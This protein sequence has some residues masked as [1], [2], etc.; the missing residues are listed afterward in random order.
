MSDSLSTGHIL[1]RMYDALLAAYGPQG[2]WPGD[3]PTEIVIGAILTQNTNWK[4]VEKAIARMKEAGLLDWAALREVPIDRLAECIRPAGYFRIKA[5]RLK[6]FVAWL[7]NRHAGTLE[8]LA[9]LSTQPLRKGLL[10]VSG[11]GRETADA[12]LLYALSRPT[13]VVD[14]YTVRV[15][16]RHNLLAKSADYEALK[17]YF[18]N[19][20]PED[21]TLF[22]EFHAL[23]VEVGKQ[24]CRRQ[25]RCEGCPLERFEHDA[26]A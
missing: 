9:H 16:R 11:I 25:A 15:A 12:I 14:A 20:L 22:N 10:G 13:F 8:S 24:H 19:H 21:A 5:K 7:W 17:S 23:L 1:G 6:N 3:S 4:N 26:K 18:E 2:W